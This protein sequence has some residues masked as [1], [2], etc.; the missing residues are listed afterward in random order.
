MKTISGFPSYAVTSSG[1]V[2][3]IQTGKEKIPKSNK[4]GRGYLYVD[5]YNNGMRKRIFIH[6]LVAEAYLNNEFGKPYV[7]H[8]DG[9]TRN[10]DVSNLEWCTPLENVTHA[11]KVLRVMHQYEKANDRREKPV[12]CYDA[13]SKRL[14][15]EYRSIREAEK[16]TGIPSSNII[17][18]LK[19][20]QSHTRGMT[21]CYVEE[22]A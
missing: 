1:K 12:R 18:Q 20:R 16:E 17:A 6:R 8:I 11:A 9:D 5:L 14:L 10:N 4:S 15:R 19:G 3:N 13:K 22:L 7:N 21:W 2:I